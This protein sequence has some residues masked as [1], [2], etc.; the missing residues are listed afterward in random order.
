MQEL[1]VTWGR[2]FRVWWLLLWRSIV[3][4][5]LLSFVAGF[6]FGLIYALLAGVFG[7]PAVG[8]SIGGGVL[9]VIIGGVWAVLVVRMALNKKYA[10]FRIVLVPHST[11]ERI[12]PR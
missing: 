3:G 9:G 1:D 7:W 4:A 6:V 5:T 8:A 2:A 11:L 10:E 12:E